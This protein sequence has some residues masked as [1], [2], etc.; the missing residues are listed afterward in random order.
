MDV[1]LLILT[2]IGSILIIGVNIYLFY[3]YNHPDDNK[4]VVGWLCRIVVIAG[5]CIV[6]GIVL[7]LP[8][9]IANSRGS[10]GGINTDILWQIMLICYWVFL[11]FLIPFMIL[12]YETDDEKPIISRICRA[13]CLEFF[14]LIAVTGLALIAFG[15]MR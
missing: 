4:D 2:I 7:L 1:W 14:L 10:G 9:D 5:S 15:S 6:L 13:F 3:M 12:L 11:V 8:L